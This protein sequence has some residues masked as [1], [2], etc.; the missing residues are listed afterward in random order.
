M[1]DQLIAKNTLAPNE[2]QIININE[3]CEEKL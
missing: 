1:D 3:I 2:L